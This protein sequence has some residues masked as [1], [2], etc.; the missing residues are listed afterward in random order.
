MS[1]IPILWNYLS[2]RTTA[3]KLCVDSHEEDQ[4]KLFPFNFEVRTFKF[5]PKFHCTNML[6]NITKKD[7]TENTLQTENMRK[8]LQ[9]GSNFF[10]S[11]YKS[12]ENYVKNHKFMIC[13]L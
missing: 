4:L 9:N 3:N 10:K 7:T 13:K 2:A 6:Q 1:L 5:K 12:M 8:H 11:K